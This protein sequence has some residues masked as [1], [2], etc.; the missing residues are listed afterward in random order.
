MAAKPPEPFPLSFSIPEGGFPCDFMIAV[1]ILPAA[2]GNPLVHVLVINWNGKEHLE[3]C[4]DSLLEQTFASVRFV[5]VDNAST[6]GSVEFVRMRYGH[7]P[8]VTVL[9]CGS[10]LGWSRGNN[11]GIERALAEGADYVFLLN[12]DTA[13]APDTVERLVAFAEAR[14][15]AGAIAPKML[16]FDQPWILNSL[17]IACSPIGSAWDVGLGRLD[18][19]GWQSPQP[20]L[21]VCG[22]AMFLRAAALRISGYLPDDFEI[23]LDDLDLCLRIWDAGYSCWSCPDAAVRHKFSATMGQGARARHK[24]YLNTRNRLRLMLRNFPR[25]RLPGCIVRYA[26][27]EVRSIGRA[28]ING[29]L[30]KSFAHVRSWAATLDSLPRIFKYRRKLI[31][32]PG[33]FWPHISHDADFFPGIELPIDGWYTARRHNGDLVRPISQRAWIRVTDGRLRVR[34]VNCYPHLGATCVDICNNGQKLATLATVDLEIAEFD[35]EGGEVSFESRHIY[36][37]ETTGD[38]IDA[39]GWINCESAS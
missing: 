7:D 29:E 35:V 25:K 9:E 32:A 18:G 1:V 3:A 11:A 23:Y 39:G 2:M 38:T 4:F 12:N 26:I 17:G 5:L 33:A 21:G 13:V 6:D 19:P 10:N 16:L 14:P 8:R 15:N 30:W 28:L 22:G 24:Y 37:A 20:V 36:E 34:H 27:G 31:L